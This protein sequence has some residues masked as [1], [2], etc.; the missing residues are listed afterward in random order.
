MPLGSQ[1]LARYENFGSIT[2]CSHGCGHVQLGQLSISLTAA[3]YVRFVA[4]VTDS[5]ASFELF[6][7]PVTESESDARSE[8]E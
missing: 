8:P 1:I 7:G 6:R 4:M 5:A 2:R 3:Q